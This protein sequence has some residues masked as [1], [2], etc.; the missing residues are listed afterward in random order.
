MDV[1]LPCDLPG[2]VNVLL[3]GV[4]EPWS[5]NTKVRVDRAGANLI[6]RQA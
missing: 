2:D 5:L 4:R 3:Y 6:L 1:R